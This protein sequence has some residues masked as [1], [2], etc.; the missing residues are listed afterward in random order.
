MARFSHTNAY[1]EFATVDVS[2]RSNNCE[3]AIDA[4]VAEVTCFDED[5]D[6]FVKDIAAWGASIQGFDDQDAASIEQTLYDNT[7][8][9]EQ[10]FVYAP[11][12]IATGYKF[13]GKVILK[14]WKVGGAM[15]GGCPFSASF[16]GSGE[17]TRSA[18]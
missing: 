9:G 1:V 12:G 5:W 4:G 11:Q 10:D 18:C 3:L 14:D 13:T 17:L 8:T 6:K 15:K 7:L 2:G 16:Q